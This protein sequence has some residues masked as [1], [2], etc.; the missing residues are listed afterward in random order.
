MK[1]SGG[2]VKKEREQIF[3]LFAENTRLKFSE[4]EKAIKIRSNMV[5]YH[6]EKMQEEGL[7]EKKDDYYYL[8]KKAER[9]LPIIPHITG[10]ELSPLPVVL[11][12]VMHKNK[13]LLIK[14]NK[15]PYQNYWCLIGGK[16][17]MEETFGAA[18]KRIVKEK[19]GLDAKYDGMASVLYERVEGEDIIKHSFIHFF[20]RMQ[21][22]SPELKQSESGELKWFSIKELDKEKVIPSDLWLIKNRLNSDIEVI[23]SEMKENT[24][25]LS[26]F[27][28]LKQ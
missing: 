14:R 10:Q 5:S 19:S 7:L 2:L 1:Y 12:A 27:R 9:Y 17:K 21:S 24:G 23:D 13:I 3:R 8:T 18:A 16:M 22:E 26:E 6:L 11:A 20:V 4:I 25:E 15:R 28:I